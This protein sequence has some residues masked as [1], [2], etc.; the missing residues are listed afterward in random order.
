MLRASQGPNN[1]GTGNQGPNSE[2]ANGMQKSFQKI[3]GV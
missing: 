2:T 1:Y 3:F